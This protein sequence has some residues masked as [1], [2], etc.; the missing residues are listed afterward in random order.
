MML[1]WLCLAGVYAQQPEQPQ[2]PAQP[3]H[4]HPHLPMCMAGQTSG[5][6]G[7]GVCDGPETA[8]NCIDDCKLQ[9]EWSG[10]ILYDN[11]TLPFKPQLFY[12]S[13]KLAV[14]VHAEPGP[15][16]W[17]VLSGGQGE[18]PTEWFSMTMGDI[19]LVKPNG[20][21]EMWNP[22]EEEWSGKVPVAV[23]ADSPT[24]TISFSGS[25]G[26]A[27]VTNGAAASAMD[28]SM[29]M[30]LQTGA[31]GKPVGHNPFF[32][33][34]PSH[35]S[36]SYIVRGCP[37]F[38]PEHCAGGI[39]KPDADTPSVDGCPTVP[40]H[41]DEFKFSVLGMLYGKALNRQHHPPPCLAGD[42]D[43]T[44]IMP[45][46]A[47]DPHA[48]NAPKDLSKYH[49]LVVT[50][51]LDLHSMGAYEAYVGS[52]ATVA[53]PLRMLYDDES[54][55]SDSVPAEPSAEP[56][57]LTTASPTQAVKREQKPQVE[58]E[59]ASLGGIEEEFPELKRRKDLQGEMLFRRLQRAENLTDMEWQKKTPL[60]EIPQGM[61]ME[62]TGNEIII[63]GAK[64]PMSLTFNEFYTTGTFT[65]KGYSV[66]SAK[67]TC[68]DVAK[69]G[70]FTKDMGTNIE[71][72]CKEGVIQG[73]ADTWDDIAEM[74][75]APN[76]TAFASR[77]AKVTLRPIFC[78][79]GT[80]PPVPA[81]QHPHW[82]GM[83]FDCPGWMSATKTVNGQLV[84]SSDDDG[85][86]LTDGVPTSGN[87]P[88]S[89]QYRCM[90][91][92]CFAIDYHFDLSSLELTNDF[93]DGF[94]TGTYFAYDPLIKVPGNWGPIDEKP[95]T[96]SPTPAPTAG[97]TPTPTPPPSQR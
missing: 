32:I 30:M 66:Q 10:G 63:K 59:Y 94:S 25:V 81:A 27:E 89:D 45:F 51:I 91:G 93:E 4:Q 55:Y 85:V 36:T 16:V 39:C 40:L 64:G 34:T 90:S 11:M 62:V 49:T 58:D 56:D 35:A 76:F 65:R 67:N 82:P 97:P 7:D 53:V 41:K 68:K 18:A 57:A 79:I 9:L 77:K 50:Q 6:C 1:A 8:T 14:N 38:L 5:C 21:E 69:M 75:G 23:G 47:G 37:N 15:P 31:E 43:C 26:S 88:K 54:K 86:V 60:A 61:S 95:A 80:R 78:E 44:P 29:T 13:E 2:Q 74:F 70:K 73:E 52:N 17:Q 92:S 3:E 42:V 48:W 71:A 20:F 12:Q 33:K 87:T 72:E 96:P 19:R 84:W 24:K 83:P 46:P 28:V 22:G